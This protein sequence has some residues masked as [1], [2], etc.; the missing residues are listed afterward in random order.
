MG[1]KH[2]YRTDTQDCGFLNRLALC[3]GAYPQE[4]LHSREDVGSPALTPSALQMQSEQGGLQ[5]ESLTLHSC[6]CHNHTEKIS[7]LGRDWL[8]NALL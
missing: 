8:G 3:S 1:W 5:L 2:V 6:L 4:M 7:C